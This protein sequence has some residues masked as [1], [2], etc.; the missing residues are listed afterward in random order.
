METAGLTTLLPVHTT[1]KALYD[2]KIARIRS[3]YRRFFF[4]SDRFA[5]IFRLECPRGALQA[6]R[7]DFIPAQ[8]SDEVFGVFHI[9][10]TARQ[11]RSVSASVNDADTI[12]TRLALVDIVDNLFGSPLIHDRHFS[13]PHLKAQQTEPNK[14]IYYS[15]KLSK[16]V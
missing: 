4:C 5:A 2:K 16:S 3:R 9:R 14:Q 1:A 12:S 7:V 15:A 8:I 10:K 11:H 13:T 6:D